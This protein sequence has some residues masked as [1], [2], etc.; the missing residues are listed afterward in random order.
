[1][2]A[3]QLGATIRLLLTGDTL[4][5]LQKWLKELG[6]KTA[7]VLGLRPRGIYEVLSHA[8]TLELVDPRGEEALVERRQTVSFLQDHVTAFTDYAWGEGEVFAEYSCS[9][10]FPVDFY[11]DGTRHAVLISLRET[12]Q[13]GDTLTFEIRRTIRGGFAAADEGW[14]TEVYHRTEELSV[15]ILFPRERR[16]QRATVT[17]RSTSKTVVLGP[18]QFRFLGDGRQQLTWEIHNPR[19]HDRYSLRWHW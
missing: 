14:E 10:G 15:T 16:C 8:T 5:V 3:T 13:R 6:Q 17:Q 18:E 1:M 4:E 12:K 9:P 7:E 11:R 2:D 19:L